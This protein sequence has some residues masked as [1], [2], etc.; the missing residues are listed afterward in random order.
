M[1]FI[2]PLTMKDI[3]FSIETLVD[4]AYLEIKEPNPFPKGKAIRNMEEYIEKLYELNSVQET[5]Q[6]QELFT[7]NRTK[8]HTKVYLISILTVP[9]DEI[10]MATEHARCFNLIQ[11]IKHHNLLISEVEVS[12]YL[13]DDVKLILKG[14]YSEV[15]N[16]AKYQIKEQGLLHHLGVYKGEM[17]REVWEDLL[18]TTINKDAEL[19]S[20]FDIEQ[21][22]LHL[23]SQPTKSLWQC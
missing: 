1:K 12:N 20:P 22:I 3:I 13:E 11:S 14:K 15:S 21:E 16:Q 2:A 10:L 23:P 18:D 4:N 6:I 9:E 8:H 5:N 7:W 17:L 19:I